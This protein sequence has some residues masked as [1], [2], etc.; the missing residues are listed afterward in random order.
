[1]ENIFVAASNLYCLRAIQ[2]AFKKEKYVEM[3]ILGCATLASIIYH[4]SE[5]K[6]G[7]KSLC[8]KNNTNITLNI[9]RFFAVSS[10]IVFALTYMDR[11]YDKNIISYS[12]FG[13]ITGMISE[14]Q[15][16]FKLPLSIE[17]PLYLVT[18]PLWHLSV[19]HIAYLL[20]NS[21]N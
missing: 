21:K 16:V 9:D 19:F 5:K 18:H 11:L 7:M 15:H 6:H 2:L 4:L 10:M 17:K 3:S 8:F 14:C 13:L 20:L 12:I 1:M